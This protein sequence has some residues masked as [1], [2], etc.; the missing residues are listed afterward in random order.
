MGACEE[1]DA[2]RSKSIIYY[3]HSMN[4]LSNNMSV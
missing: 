2:E 3:A 4:I 1:D